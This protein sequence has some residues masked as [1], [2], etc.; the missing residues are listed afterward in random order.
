M[1]DRL[2]ASFARFVLIIG[3]VTAAFSARAAILDENDI[4]G[5]A[6]LSAVIQAFE[7]DV[8]AAIHDLPPGDAEQIESYS[9]VGLNLEAAHERLNNIFMLAAVSVYMESL[10]DQV[11]ILKLMHEQLL[12]RTKNLLNEKREAIASMAAAHPENEVFAAYR[13]RANAIL[14]D[15]AIP[16]IDEL[17][18]KIDALRREAPAPPN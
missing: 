6:R 1:Y 9:Y 8:R 10:P 14:G 18:R 4:G 13:T 3:L 2:A 17:Y 5:L 7:D 11:V 16:L 15:S 12:P